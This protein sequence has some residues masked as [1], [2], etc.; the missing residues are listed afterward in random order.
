MRERVSGAVELGQRNDVVAHLGD[1]DQRV[2]DCRHS[3]TNAQRF[4]PSLERGDALLENPISRISDS[5][6]NI[7]LNFE[8]EQRCSMFGAIE[9]KRD[10]LIDRDRHGVS[11]GVAI[12]TLREL[13][14]SLAS[15]GAGPAILDR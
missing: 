10:R 2:V 11:R 7:A 6:V 1:V 15:C 9:L 8:V 12:V 13:R 5:G 4:N 14:S 3:R